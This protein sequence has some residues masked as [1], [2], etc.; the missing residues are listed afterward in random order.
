MRSML[1]RRGTGLTENDFDELE[2]QLTRHLS[3]SQTSLSQANPES[4]RFDLEVFLKKMFARSQDEGL[5]RR[6]S[7]VVFEDLCVDGIGSG[8][9][10]GETV[11]SVFMKPL[12]IFSNWKQFRHKPVK[13]I[14]QNFTGAV[15]PGEMFLVLGRP[16]AGCSTLLKTLANNTHSYSDIRGEISF[17]GI[18][19]EEMSKNFA[20]DVAYLPEDDIHL[21]V[22]TVGE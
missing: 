15:Q 13:H 17:G 5:H 21:P 16:G 22:L 6:E 20:G 4:E 8:V 9:T 18:S 19:P 3:R 7:S 1:T 11:G 10:F 14:L 2:R 12:S